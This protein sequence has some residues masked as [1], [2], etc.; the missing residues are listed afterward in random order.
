M[1]LAKHAPS[2]LQD[3]RN[4]SYVDYL[5]PYCKVHLPHMAETFGQTTEDVKQSLAHLIG[6]GDI[7][8]ARIDCRTET[9]LRSKGEARNKKTQERVQRLQEAVLNDTYAFIVRLAVLE[10]EPS[11]GRSRAAYEYNEDVLGHSS[12]DEDSDTQMV[13]NNIAN[14]ED[15]MF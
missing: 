14:P 12:D 2:L 13:C 9:L 15:D 8:H 7:A 6:T 1:V 5:R 4:R 10:H 11:G 3:I